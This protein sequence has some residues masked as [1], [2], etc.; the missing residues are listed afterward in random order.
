MS[1]WLQSKLG[2]GKGKGERERAAPQTVASPRS[3]PGDGARSSVLGTPPASPAAAAP[4]P[5]PTPPESARRLME[6]PSPRKLSTNAHVVSMLDLSSTEVLRA[7]VGAMWAKYSAA[8][9]SGQCTE[10]TLSKLLRSVLASYQ[11]EWDRWHADLELVDA[12]ASPLYLGRLLSTPAVQTDECVHVL[13]GV[14]RFLAELPVAFAPERRGTRP[15]D[16]AVHLFTLLMLARTHE[17]TAQLA[18]QGGPALALQL[19]RAAFFELRSLTEQRA[20]YQAASVDRLVA[21]AEW[22]LAVALHLVAALAG[23]MNGWVRYAAQG[24]EEKEQLEAEET[25]YRDSKAALLQ[26][27]ALRALRDLLVFLAAPGR[28]ADALPEAHVTLLSLALN[29]TGNLLFLDPRAQQ[30]VR[31]VNLLDAVVGLLRWPSAAAA[32][33]REYQMQLLAVQ[34]LREATLASGASN[35]KRVAQLGAY[36]ALMD[37]LLWVS[38]HYAPPPDSIAPQH[39]TLLHTAASHSAALPAHSAAPESQPLPPP[40]PLPRQACP[41]LSNLLDAMLGLCTNQQRRMSGRATDSMAGNSAYKFVVSTLLDLFKEEI[42][43]SVA[44]TRARRRLLATVELQLQVLDTLARLFQAVPAAVDIAHKYRMWDVLFSPYFYRIALPSS[45]VTCRFKEQ[46]LSF[47]CFVATM[48]GHDPVTECGKLLN[49]LAEEYHRQD[50]VLEVGTA[51]TRILH[52]NLVEAQRALLRLDLFPILSVVIEIQINMSHYYALSPPTGVDATP[53]PYAREAFTSARWALLHVVQ[54]SVASSEELQ[55]AALR[56]QR[57]VECL[58]SL[59]LDTEF[60]RFALQ[61]LLALMGFVVSNVRELPADSLNIFYTYFG[62]ARRMQTSPL[63]GHHKLLLLMLNG[64]TQVVEKH[65]SAAQ[66]VLREVD[67]FALLMALANGENRPERLAALTMEVLRTL[68]SLLAGHAANKEYFRAA[69]GYEALHVLIARTIAAHAAFDVHTLLRLLFGMLLELDPDFFAESLASGGPAPPIQNPDVIPLL[70]RFLPSATKPA[71]QALLTMFA[72]LIEKNTL[73]QSFCCAQSLVFVLLRQVSELDPEIAAKVVSLLEILG[74][75]SITVRELKR[76]FA[77]LKAEG[78]SRSLLSPLLLKALQFMAFSRSEGPDMFFNFDGRT[79]GMALP[80]TLRWP[81]KGGMTFCVWLRIESYD[82]PD[83]KPNYQPRLWSFITESGSG[84]ELLFASKCLV[85]QVITPTE[86]RP[87]P[88]SDFVFRE[89]KWY[90][91]ALTMSNAARLSFSQ[92]EVRLFVDGQPRQ[93]AQAKYPAFVEPLKHAR[94]GTNAEMHTAS[95]RIYRESPFLGQLGSVYFFDDALTPQAVSAWHALGPNYCG[96]FLPSE[97][98]A[99]DGPLQ[100]GSLAGKVHVAYNCRAMDGRRCLDTS[101]SGADAWALGNLNACITRDVKDM[102]CSFGGIRALVPLFAQLDLPLGARITAGAPDKSLV[103]LLALIGEMLSDSPANQAEMARSHGFAAIASLL[104]Q[105]SPPHFTPETLIVIQDLQHK[106]S[107]PALV[108]H[109]YLHLL[110]DFKIWINTPVDLQCELLQLLALDFRARRDYFRSVVRAALLLDIVRLFFYAVPG[111][112]PDVFVFS[113]R[114]PRPADA[115]LKR[116]RTALLSLVFILC[117]ERAQLADAAALVG[118]LV[119]NAHDTAVCTEVLAL[120]HSLLALPV[121]NGM[122]EH[123]YAL[124]GTD[125]FLGVLRLPVPEAM[126]VL[127]IRCLGIL[128]APASASL[129]SKKRPAIAAELAPLTGLLS[130]YPFTEVLFRALWNVLTQ[131]GANEPD[132]AQASPRIVCPAILPTLLKLLLSADVVM[133]QHV[134]TE[135]CVLLSS[136]EENAEAFLSSCY[137]W[138]SQLFLLLADK[139]EARFAAEAAVVEQMLFNLLQALLLH[140]LKHGKKQGQRAVEATLLM[141]A[142]RSTLD[143]AAV[144]RKLFMRL[145]KALQQEIRAAA[146]RE[147][148]SFVHAYELLKEVRAPSLCPQPHVTHVTPAGR[149]APLAARSEPPGLLRAARGLHVL[150][151]HTVHR[152]AAPEDAARQPGAPRRRLLLRRHQHLACTCLSPP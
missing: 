114:R 151:P 47:V 98:P 13:R 90:S 129:R 53:L 96:S 127:S 150:H 45:A 56:D 72:P 113:A 25:L 40:P 152:R 24:D 133:R 91:L 41:Q 62:L 43:P 108:H 61:Q 78:N 144:A 80:E 142:E 68:S 122:A 21:L 115:D 44:N 134:L 77:L 121:A 88:F 85:L 130:T 27:G 35:A 49:L 136:S 31:E 39:E 145:L 117:E 48:R 37:V 54:S 140:E 147:G 63:P 16:S 119:G 132:E 2:S 60:R 22:A 105:V 149:S 32:L 89:G 125:V 135:L 69:V 8:L 112:D 103:Q 18:A 19:L 17:N 107:L 110:L 71:A 104:E 34:V 97:L 1:N 74:T 67:V 141:L 6:N 126:R 73:N 28:L 66:S 148:V 81:S 58:F 124:G 120:L 100:D 52:Y 7:S 109:V 4:S 14:R 59:L 46:L 83:G 101:G 111:P 102:M 76:L 84:I 93:R 82:D 57:L 50:C 75:F 15:P 23:C 123:I 143:H 33:A 118:F 64:V 86:R 116:L 5:R 99:G 128:L 138:Q 106:I 137:G 94:I 95:H 139:P 36:E 3:S 10:E 79:A 26:G 87:V 65:K 42:R 92:S 70:F 11:P 146:P 30:G 131:G 51:L 29:A 38:Y 9:M 55:R 12:L 20:R